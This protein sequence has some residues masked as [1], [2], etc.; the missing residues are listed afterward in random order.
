MCEVESYLYEK[1]L[2][3]EYKPNKC[4]SKST[5]KTRVSNLKTLCKCLFDCNTIDIDKIFNKSK[6]VCKLIKSIYEGD[7]TSYER[8]MIKKRKGTPNFKKKAECYSTALWFIMKIYNRT[9]KDFVELNKVI[10]T[11]NQEY[12]EPNPSKVGSG[13]NYNYILNKYDELSKDNCITLPKPKRGKKKEYNKKY[14]KMRAY[15]ILSLFIEIVPLRQMSFLNCKWGNPIDKSCNY[16]DLDNKKIYMYKYK[17]H[18]KHGDKVYEINDKLHIILKKWGSHP[19][20]D[21]SNNI[22]SEYC[23][24]NVLGIKNKSQPITSQTCSKLIKKFCNFTTNDIRNHFVSEKVS[25]LP[26]SQKNK[27][28]TDMQHCPST[29]ALV[30]NK[31]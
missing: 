29:Q 24:P 19:F 14:E 8:V 18:S 31:Y 21:G 15:T 1:G 10:N 2:K 25:K 27:I 30:Y 26:P 17:T 9:N 7:I 5:I 28:A 20:N 16:I 12:Q 11:N 3:T 22:V 6:E 23:F 4:Y 13:I